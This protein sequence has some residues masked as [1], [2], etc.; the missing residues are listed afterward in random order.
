MHGAWLIDELGRHGHRLSPGT[1]YPLLH[2]LESAGLVRS[3]PVVVEG[4]TLTCVLRP[5][6]RAARRCATA[7]AWCASWPTRCSRH[8]D[9]ARPDVDCDAPGHQRCR[10]RVHRRLDSRR[11]WP[12]APPG[13]D[14]PHPRARRHRPGRSF[15]VWKIHAAALLQPPRSLVRG[16]DHLPRHRH[17][18]TRCAAGCVATSPWSSRSRL[19]SPGT[20]LDNL[21]AADPDLDEA[22]VRGNCSPVCVSAP[23]ILERNAGELSGGEAQRLCLARSLAVEPD[24]VLMDEVTS[25]G[26]SRR[27]RRALMPSPAAL[28]DA[29]TPVVWV[30]HDLA[31]ARRL[32]DTPCWSSTR[33]ASPTRRRPTPTW[34]RGARGE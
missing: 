16:H 13:G 22:Q 4:R 29:D 30:T 12:L 9:R 23:E 5:P 26:R 18:R 31:Q 24:V 11:R 25:S 1:L 28:A 15:R 20:G 2:R 34:R 27:P 17:H 8:D 6:L 10:V 19:R 32:A 14:R 21:R 7:G 33:V 3:R